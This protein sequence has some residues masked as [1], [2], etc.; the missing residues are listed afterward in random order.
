MANT[1]TVDMLDWPLD[2]EITSGDFSV[3]EDAFGTVVFRTPKWS[4]KGITLAQ[5]LRDGAFGGNSLRVGFVNRIVRK[6]KTERAA[7]ALVAEVK[8]NGIDVKNLVS[9]KFELPIAVQARNMSLD[10][11]RKTISELQEL[12]K[13]AAQAPAKD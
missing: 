9:G 12:E 8:A 1:I 5:I 11:L 13:V 7:E 6:L 2:L 3:K 10:D 4:C